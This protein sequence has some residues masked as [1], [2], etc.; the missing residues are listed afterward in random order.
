[1]QAPAS[2]QAGDW[3]TAGLWVG[4]LGVGM[5]ADR[6]VGGWIAS[7]PNSTQDNLGKAFEPFGQSVSFILLGGFAAQGYWG[8]D[9]RALQTAQEG[10]EVSLLG[11]G[12]AVTTLKQ[13]SGR[14]RPNEV[15]FGASP[16]LFSGKSSFPSGHTAQAFGVATVIAENYG[17]DHAW[18]PWVAYGTAGMVGWQRV[19]SRHHNP[20]DVIAGAAIG[21]YTAQ[22][23]VRRHRATRA[24]A[25]SDWEVS[26]TVLP[27]GLII[28]ARRT[29]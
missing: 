6:R 22:W 14:A 20:T 16:R 18:V 23:V 3:A 7:H 15:G 9:A 1:V 29:F 24:A 10:M 13:V 12:L 28:G 25:A 4:G 8:D 2:F 27:D 21:Y 17:A 5:Q 19:Y 11:A 26:P